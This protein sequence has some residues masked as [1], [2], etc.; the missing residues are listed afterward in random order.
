MIKKL[1]MA[2]AMVM[3]VGMAYAAD[4]TTSMKSVTEHGDLLID[5]L[6]DDK[7]LEVVRIEYD[8]IFSSDNVKSIIRNF[9]KGYTYYIMGFADDR[10][11]DLD[12]ELYR[13]NAS[14]DWEF[15]DKDTETDS[16]PVLV[17]NIT[18]SGEYMIRVKA[19]SFAGTSKGAHYGLII[20]HD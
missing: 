2:I 4:K 18:Q 9:S 7:K 20:A 3:T 8:L 15:L 13:K 19:A 6:E 5:Y 17:Y 14:G 11:K 16:T 12:L 10:V 1:M